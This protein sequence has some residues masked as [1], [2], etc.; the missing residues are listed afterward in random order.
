MLRLLLEGFGVW[1]AVS[2]VL[3]LLLGQLMSDRS[4]SALEPTI[5]AFTPQ[6]FDRGATTARAAS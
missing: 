3:G 1:L 4:R 5:D 2:T 6:G